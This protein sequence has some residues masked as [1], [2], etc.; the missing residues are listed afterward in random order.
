[1][2]PELYLIIEGGSLYT[3]LNGSLWWSCKM[4]CCRRTRPK[5][6]TW[7]IPLADATTLWLIR[8]AKHYHYNYYY[9]YL[10][11]LLLVIYDMHCTPCKSWCCFWL[12][13]V[14]LLVA[15]IC[16]WLLIKGCVAGCT[17]VVTVRVGPSVLTL[18]RAARSCLYVEK[19]GSLLLIVYHKTRAT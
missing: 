7:P 3:S 6:S 18:D 14:V 11:L 19:G 2:S 8:C 17:Q 13:K 9:Y 4:L 16:F 15:P 12:S 1:M 10:L 5:P